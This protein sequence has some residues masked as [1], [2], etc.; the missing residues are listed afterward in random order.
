MTTATVRYEA[1]QPGH[2]PR[3]VGP[4]L[5]TPQWAAWVLK[6]LNTHNRP[7]RPTV[8]SRYARDMAEGNWRLTHQGIAFSPAPVL[9]DGQHRLMAVCLSKASVPCHV[10]TGVG[11]EAQLVVD[12]HVPRRTEDALTLAGTPVT[13]NEASVAAAMRLGPVRTQ[14][15]KAKLT[16]T[17]TATFFLRH[18]APIRWA[19]RLQGKHVRVLTTA[20]VTAVYARAYYHA[21]RQAV[22]WFSDVLTH[23]QA[24]RL[25][26]V[27]NTA[28]ACRS[29]LLS[30]GTSGGQAKSEL[31]RKTQRALRAFLDGE[32]LRKVYGTDED[33]F[34]LPD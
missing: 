7:V 27:E 5:V 3:S 15:G 6:E 9:L 21:D 24:V 10:F 14:M 29:A 22:A 33:L 23:G 26:P 32:V 18:E 11:A 1:L 34:P 30:A 19:C 12:D 8:V 28:L 20:S 16:K 17:E 2:L 25:E 13:R 31:Y 4:W